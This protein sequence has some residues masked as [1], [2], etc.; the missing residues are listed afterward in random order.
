MRLD[1]AGV[2]LL[3][4]E[5]E[6]TTAGLHLRRRDKVQWNWDEL[7]TEGPK[8]SLTGPFCKAEKTKC[9]PPHGGKE[10]VILEG[11]AV[12]VSVAFKDITYKPR[13][14][15]LSSELRWDSLVD[16]GKPDKISWAGE[17]QPRLEMDLFDS[18]M[19]EEI[20]RNLVA[21]MEKDKTHYLQRIPFLALSEDGISGLV[22]SCVVEELIRLLRNEDTDSELGALASACLESMLRNGRQIVSPKLEEIDI[23]NLVSALL[24]RSTPKQQLIH[25]VF[26]ATWVENSPR[27]GYEIPSDVWFTVVK[28]LPKFVKPDFPEAD[29]TQAL[30]CSTTFLEIDRFLGTLTAGDLDMTNKFLLF[31]FNHDHWRG[32]QNAVT[33]VGKLAEQRVFH[34]ALK[35]LVPQIAASLEDDSWSVRVAALTTL[36]KLSEQSIFH[37]AIRDLVPQIATLL[38]DGTI[39]VRVSAVTTMGK[40]AE[41]GKSSLH[42]LTLLSFVPSC[43]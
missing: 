1:L 19:A 10:R 37:E 20:G 43:I 40:L 16:R 32:R 21:A 36:G 41:Q 34:G 12:H 35:D 29:V 7:R 38:K 6:A 27:Q 25:S 22:S 30:R 23:A 4:M 24:S 26:L 42:L 9:W 8:E 11:Q 33:A 18:S 3:W 31:Q 5:N 28:L 17:W 2:P 39:N 14:L 15:L 13:A